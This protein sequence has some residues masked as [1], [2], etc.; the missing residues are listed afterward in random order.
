MAQETRNPAFLQQ[1]QQEPTRDEP[2]S[3]GASLAGI[4]PASLFASFTDRIS[5]LPTSHPAGLNVGQVKDLAVGL[6]DKLRLGETPSV[7]ADATAR[8]AFG[9]G[10]EAI[11]TSVGYIWNEATGFWEFTSGVATGPGTGGTGIGGGFFGGGRRAG[12]GGGGTVERRNIGF[13]PSGSNLF[14]WRV[15]FG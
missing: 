7:I 1:L 15:N 5:V 10:F 2:I 11:L 8:T 6:I 14:N 9:E 4:T 13:A 3:T 12:G